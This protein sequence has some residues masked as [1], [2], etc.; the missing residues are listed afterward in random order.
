MNNYCTKCG[1]KL[2]R[3]SNKC[4]NCN[5]AVVDINKDLDFKRKKIKKNILIFIVLFLSLI[6][7]NY[8]YS[9]IKVSINS[10]KLFSSL[11]YN[12]IKLDDKTPCMA[13]SN[14]A[15][16]S[17]CSN[18]DYVIN[19]HNYLYNIYLKNGILL[20]IPIRYS[21]TDSDMNNFK[22]INN[23]IKNYEKL[24]N[25]LEQFKNKFSFD[26]ITQTE[27]ILICQKILRYILKIQTF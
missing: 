4:P 6:V 5:L 17:D 18:R 12:K 21:S 26:Y 2:K 25:T 13:C 3:F 1:Y 16:D 24:E 8:F 20:K 22:N 14:D 15:C 27:V 9:T 23:I 10:K 11:E 19:C 7:F